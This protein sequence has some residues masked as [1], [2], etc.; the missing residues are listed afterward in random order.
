[1]IFRYKNFWLKM[2]IQL[3]VIIIIVY[4]AGYL[5]NFLIILFS[6][7]LHEIAHILCA[8]S[9]GKRVYCIRFMA[10]G[11]SASIEQYDC[12][13]R[14]LKEIAINLSGPVMNICIFLLSYIS[15]LSEI[16]SYPSLKLLRLS[17][18]YLAGLNLLPVLPLDGGKIFKDIL[19]YK[20]DIY[21]AYAY[22]RIVSKTI[23]SILFVLGIIQIIFNNHNFSLMLLG[24]YLFMLQDKFYKYG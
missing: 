13:C 2:D 24:C 12:I 11:I 9:F 4:L 20:I 1:M 7:L 23:A 17:N 14:K 10:A 15:I 16:I 6:M 19:T 5:K 22:I 3:I 21:S 18:L 8:I